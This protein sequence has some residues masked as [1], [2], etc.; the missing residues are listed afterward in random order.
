MSE[1]PALQPINFVQDIA[2]ADD[3][4]R[5][6]TPHISV[7]AVEDKV[8]V[9]VKAAYYVAHPNEPGHFFDFIELYANGT[10]IARFSGSPGVVDPSISIALNVPGGTKLT[11]LASC[12]L[13]G[14]WKAEAIVG[15][16]SE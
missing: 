14:V 16:D 7:S 5:K 3:F 15:V 12:N 9:T 6:H 4:T 1:F 8:H 13:H 11:A 2:S 10:P